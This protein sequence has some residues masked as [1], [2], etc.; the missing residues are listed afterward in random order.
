MIVLDDKK[1]PWQEGLT[2]ASLLA[3]LE[4]GHAYAVVKLN[5]RL[6][7]RPHFDMTP[8][9]DEARVRLVP[10]IAGG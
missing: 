3:N 1:I 7:S 10:M 5:G 2:V 6:I 4:D 8:V 9:P